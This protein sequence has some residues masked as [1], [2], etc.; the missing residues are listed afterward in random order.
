VRISQLADQVGVPVSTVRYYERIGL[1]AEP[2][3]TASGYRKYDVD[4]ATQLLFITRARKLGLNCDQIAELLPIWA[5]ADCLDAQTEVLRLIDDK[6]TEI[7]ARIEELAAFSAQ[8]DAV[9]AELGATPPPHACRTD[10][11]CCV[12]SGPTGFEPFEGLRPL[13]LSGAR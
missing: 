13:P 3:R 1:M 7:A 11:S 2:G 4:S 10:L 8:L 5:G 9:R 12:P 6:K